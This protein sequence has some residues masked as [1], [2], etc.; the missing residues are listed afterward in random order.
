MLCDGYFC[1]E[2]NKSV[3]ER[4]KLIKNILY[5]IAD[6]KGGVMTML[7]ILIEHHFYLSR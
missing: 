3:Q 1:V 4:A 5:G 7:I 6:Y 2:L